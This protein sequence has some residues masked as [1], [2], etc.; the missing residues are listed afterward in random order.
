M[1]LHGRMRVLL[2]CALVVAV[3]LSAHFAAAGLGGLSTAAL[4]AAG[5]GVGAS[6][7]PDRLCWLVWWALMLGAFDARLD[8]ALAAGGL[9]GGVRVARRERCGPR[10]DGFMRSSS[11]LARVLYVTASFVSVRAALYRHTSTQQTCIRTAQTHVGTHVSRFRHVGRAATR[12]RRR[13]RA[14]RAG[15][16]R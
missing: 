9:R 6:M 3:A 2:A 4:L 7:G 8:T 12:R 14:V 10:A 13:K 11:L 15:S 16:S 1:P 5:A